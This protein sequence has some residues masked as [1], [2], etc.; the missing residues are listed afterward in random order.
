MQ[1]AKPE[2]I[3]HMAAQSLVRRSYIE[4]VET[5]ST[6]VMGTVYL[7]EA[8]RQTPSVRVINVTSDKCYEN[9]EWVWGYREDEPMGAQTHMAVKVAPNLSPLLIV[10]RFQSCQI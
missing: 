10:T 8:A 1:Q 9:K 5:Y 6:N 2:I 4:P 3:I 7:L